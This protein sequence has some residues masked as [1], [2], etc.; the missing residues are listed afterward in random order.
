MLLRVLGIAFI[1]LSIGLVGFD[2]QTNAKPPK[3]ILGFKMRDID[4]KEVAL[5]AE[6]KGA[7]QALMEAAERWARA[8]GYRRLTLSVFEENRRARRLY[9][10][11]GFQPDT[12]KYIKAL[13]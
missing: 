1:V 3:N 10:W 8:Q 4:G 6:G 12:I 5:T 13:A 9:E 11:R 2:F 7:G